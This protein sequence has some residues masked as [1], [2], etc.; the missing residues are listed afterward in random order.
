MINILKKTKPSII[1]GQDE[2]REAIRAGIDLNLPVLL[3]GETG[4]GKTTIVH[5]I[6]DD[7]D[8]PF[9]RLNL[10][11]QTSIDEFVGKLVIRDGD[12]IWQDGVL[13]RCMKE[14][15]WLLCDEVNAAL[16]EIL[17]VLQSLLD[18]DRYILLSANEGEIV[19]PHKDFRFF[20]S[21]NPYDEYAGTKELNK[22]F[23]DRFAIVVQFDYPGL[24]TESGIL[25]SRTHLSNTQAAFVASVGFK[26]RGAKENE[27]LYFTCSTRDLLFWAKIAERFGLQR[28]FEITIVNK[29]NKEDRP[30][31]WKIFRGISATPSFNQTP[32]A[33]EKPKGGEESEEDGQDS[34]NGYGDGDEG[35]DE[36]KDG[37]DSN[38]DKQDS[39]N[40]QK[41]KEKDSKGKGK[42]EDKKLSELSKVSDISKEDLEGKLINR[43]ITFSAEA[44][45]FK[46]STLPH[47]GVLGKGKKIIAE[48]K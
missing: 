37:N 17:F 24:V 6:A 15:G 29:A 31:L 26:I 48:T 3:I 8:R 28:A 47:K 40:K 36:G 42:P 22:A 38:A 45:D 33:I 14:G 39:E 5:E 7:M 30:V 23:L 2:N 27:E 25:K 35:G 19:R 18:D 1:Q 4:T 21:M 11:G 10:N 13:I 43:V 34:E 20:A 41:Q 9:V 32:D 44:K 16:P 46:T 12:T